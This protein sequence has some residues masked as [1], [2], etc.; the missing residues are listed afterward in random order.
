MRSFVRLVLSVVVF[1]AVAVS[2]GVGTADAGRPRPVR[3]VGTA[4][5][6]GAAVSIGGARQSRA[7]TINLTSRNVKLASMTTVP[8]SSRGSFL[9]H[10][11]LRGRGRAGKLGGVVP[12]LGDQEVDATATFA[13]DPGR[14]WR[15]SPSAT[16][17]RMTR[18]GPSL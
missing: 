4:D 2:A 15:S 9:A 17:A 16:T 7:V 6:C 10:S 11:D 14:P 18:R 13:M 5:Y 3:C 8:G 12:G 1:G